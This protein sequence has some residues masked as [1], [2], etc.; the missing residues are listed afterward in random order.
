MNQLLYNM[1]ISMYQLSFVMKMHVNKL[2][3]N[4]KHIHEFF[5]YFMM[6]I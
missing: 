6:R 4:G 3:L 2:L 5:S 1:R